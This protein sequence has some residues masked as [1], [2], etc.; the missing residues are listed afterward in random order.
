MSGP[1][2]QKEIQITNG[3]VEAKTWNHERAAIENWNARVND[4]QTGQGL[5]VFEVWL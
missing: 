5:D 4:D 1:A 2:V 3:V